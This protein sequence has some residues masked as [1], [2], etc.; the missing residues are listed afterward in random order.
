MH[1]FIRYSIALAVATA[2][3]AGVATQSHSIVLL[4]GIF[5]VFA[6]TVAIGLRY[7]KLMLDSENENRWTSS[8]FAGGLTFGF[9]SLTQSQG[10]EFQIGAGILGFGLALFGVATGFWMADSNAM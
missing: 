5:Q 4:A 1:R 2:I 7:P 9:I 3:T 10:D 8:I 6:L